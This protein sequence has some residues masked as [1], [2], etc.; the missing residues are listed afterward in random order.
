MELKLTA[1]R[2]MEFEERTGV[3]L[4]LYLKEVAATGEISMK[5]M[6]ELFKSM[7]DGYTVDDFDNWQAPYTEKATAIMNAVKEFTEGK[8]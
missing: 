4:L 3:D 6:V 7:G 1:K 8:N 5:M 2:A